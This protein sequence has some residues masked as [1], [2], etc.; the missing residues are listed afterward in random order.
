M[1]LEYIPDSQVCSTHYSFE[2]DEKEDVILSVEITGGCHGNLQGIKALLC[3]MK[4]TEA[5]KRLENIC[6]GSKNTSCPDQIAR[7]LKM[8]YLEKKG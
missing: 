5:V 8:E 1:H 2:I 6:C 4:V 7:A 3:G